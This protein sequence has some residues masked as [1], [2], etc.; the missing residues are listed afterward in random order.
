M[1]NPN[2]EKSYV[3]A[4]EILVRSNAISNFPFNPIVLVKELSEIRCKTFATARRYGVDITDFGSESAIIMKIGNKSIIF[5]DDTKLQTHINFSIIHEFGHTEL[6]H[7]FSKKEHETY[8]RNEVETNYFTAQLLMPEQLLRELQRRG[9]LITVQFLV[10]KFGV[11]RQAA[12]KRIETLAKTNIEWF[13][14]S[15]KE[16]D[17]IILFKYAR[18]LDNVCPQSNLYS[19]EDELLFQEERSKWY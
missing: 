13:S 14:R 8:I 9:V 11:S 15:Q 12:N 19:Y 10:D 3:K 5:Y 2:F 1:K 4:N 7:D 17:D 18:F 6:D 16:Y